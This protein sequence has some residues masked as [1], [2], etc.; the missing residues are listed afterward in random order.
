M[1]SSTRCVVVQF[2]ERT[3]RN[4]VNES[5]S[6]LPPPSPPS[7]LLPAP[8]SS[9]LYALFDTID[10]YRG[11][12]PQRAN[13][14]F[15]FHVAA[16]VLY[17]RVWLWHTTPAAM[18]LP[19]ATGFGWFF[20]YL[21]FCSYT[22]QLVQFALCVLCRILPSEKARVVTSIA[23]DRLACALFG[24][25]NMISAMFY[26]IESTGGKGLIDASG[27]GAK[28]WWL[29]ETVHMLNSIIAWIDLFLVEERTFHGHSRALIVFFI[30]TYCS[31][32]LVVKRVHGTF[33]YPLMNILPFPWGFVGLAAAASCVLLSIFELGRRLK[34]AQR[35]R[36]RRG[37]PSSR[38]ER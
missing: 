30:V 34:D 28:P 13:V 18:A 3:R 16:L 32:A 36:R 9:S 8:D 2:V 14:E 21:T 25:A 26:T 23:A 19:G 10:S 5:H 1:A 4:A 15:I 37:D 7:L 20:R 31:W 22:L 33:P 12:I 11:L 35:N 38:K 6:P 29:G 24:L 17:S 27:R